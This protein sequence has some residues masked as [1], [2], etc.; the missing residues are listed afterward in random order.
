MIKIPLKLTESQRLRLKTKIISGIGIFY[1]PSLN[2]LSPF[3]LY[4]FNKFKLIWSWE[5]F[6]IMFGLLLEG[7]RE[8]RSKP[9]LYNVLLG[10]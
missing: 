1:G 7:I 9:F 10:D 8:A 6:L 3:S 4:D 2:I 5:I